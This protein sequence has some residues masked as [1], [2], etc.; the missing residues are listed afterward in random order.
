[1]D[2]L[3][4]FES[5][6]KAGKHRNEEGLA[7]FL[8][9]QF[10]NRY[11]AS[12]GIVPYVIIKEGLGYYGIQLDYF[13]CKV[14]GI[15]QKT[16]GRM[17][18]AGNVENWTTGGPGDHGLDT[19][20]QCQ[21]GVATDQLIIQAISHMRLP[22]YPSHTHLNCRHKRWARSYELVFE[23]A[24]ILILRNRDLEILNDPYCTQR[25]LCKLDP[26]IDMHEHLGGF[27]FTSSP[28]GKRVVVTGDGRLL[29][30]SNKNLWEDYMSGQTPY[31][32][33]LT[34]ETELNSM[35]SNLVTK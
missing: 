27:I 28:S 15:S 5:W 25:V 35:L 6:R 14:N 31:N 12:H 33:A 9:L 21:N 26:K 29:N 16:I 18:M 8:A 20:I 24:T 4:V 7:W 30:G 11:Y 10:C 17:T 32:L 3:S 2:T 22:L 34:I 19:S 23:I 1:M 13:Q